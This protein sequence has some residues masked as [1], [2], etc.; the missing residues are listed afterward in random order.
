LSTHFQI[1]QGDLE[2]LVLNLG[3]G[4]F[5]IIQKNQK[6]HKYFE[7]AVKSAFEKT[8]EKLRPE[9]KEKM[10]ALIRTRFNIEPL[11]KNHEFNYDFIKTAAQVKIKTET[12]HHHKNE[13]FERTGQTNHIR[14]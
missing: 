1:L 12:S 9:M 13:L 5:E 4:A 8:K 2:F 11:E 14:H 7:D 3:D 10:M 6:E